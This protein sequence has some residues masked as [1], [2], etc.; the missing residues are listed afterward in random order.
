MAARRATAQPAVPQTLAWI[1]GLINWF[2]DIE[3]LISTAAPF[4]AAFAKRIAPRALPG[5]GWLLLAADISNAL[6]GI[7]GAPLVGRL[8]KAKAWQD[9]IQAAALRRLPPAQRL[10]PDTVRAGIG[11]L[12]EAGQALKTLTGYG[13]QLGGIM[14]T[15]SETIWAIIRA[16][17]ETRAITVRGPISTDPLAAAWRVIFGAWKWTPYLPYASRE[18][19]AAALFATSAA[20]DY[21]DQHGPETL[22]TARLDALRTTPIPDIEHPRQTWRTVTPDPTALLSRPID[23]GTDITP[24]RPAPLEDW[25]AHLAPRYDDAAALWNTN[26]HDD[27]RLATLAAR[28]AVQSLLLGRLA[29]PDTFDPTAPLTPQERWALRTLESGFLPPILSRPGDINFYHWRSPEYGRDL[30]LNIIT[31]PGTTRPPIHEP[32]ILRRRTR[33][34][35]D[36]IFTTFTTSAAY[37]YGRRKTFEYWGPPPVAWHRPITIPL[38]PNGPILPLDIWTAAPKYIEAWALG[39]YS[40]LAAILEL[41][42]QAVDARTR[43]DNTLPTNLPTPGQRPHWWNEQINWWFRRGPTYTRDLKQPPI[44]TPP[45]NPWYT[46]PQPINIPY[47]AAIR[48]ATHTGPLGYLVPEWTK[49]VYFEPPPETK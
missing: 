27:D 13:L 37:Y 22:N 24:F 26:H 14:A 8:P 34:L 3:D 43:Q 45:L 1:P 29:D 19:Q 10:F 36:L 49:D 35:T 40:P 33:K 11:Y 23:T 21:I 16:P 9:L 41:W 44:A 28:T 47:W 30:S 2:D 48:G 42:G 25:I 5:I 38:D 15:I 17:L 18:R 32:T 39:P 31:E 12:L 4:L 20:A 6:V 46:T 7:L